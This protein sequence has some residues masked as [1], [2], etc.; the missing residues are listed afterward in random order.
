VEQLVRDLGFSMVPQG[1]LL[2][3]SLL[4]FVVLRFRCHRYSDLGLEDLA[5]ESRNVHHMAEMLVR[6]CCFL[7]V[8]LN[9]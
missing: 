5:V 1:S 4:P 7:V 6:T 9:T 2:A 8:L 3:S